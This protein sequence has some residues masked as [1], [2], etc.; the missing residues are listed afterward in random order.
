[1]IELA[2]SSGS[3]RRPSRI[4]LMLARNPGFSMAFSTMGV[5][6]MV[7]ATA[8]TVM[9]CSAHSAAMDLVRVHTPPLAAVYAARNGA[10]DHAYL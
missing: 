6:V 8:F 10:A 7:G 5:R 3:A 1:M 2:I 4:F 9:P